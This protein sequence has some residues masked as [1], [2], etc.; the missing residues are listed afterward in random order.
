MNNLSN[1]NFKDDNKKELLSR[2]V[3]RYLRNEVINRMSNF[4][5]DLLLSESEIS[6]TFNVSRTPVR[7]AINRLYAEGLIVINPNRGILINKLSLDDLNELMQIRIAIEGLAIKFASKNIT[8]KKIDKLK[9]ILFKLKECA[10]S[11]NNKCFS[12]LDTSFHDLIVDF[13]KSKRLKSIYTN[14]QDQY[15]AF[16]IKSFNNLSRLEEAY[17]E[18]EKIISALESYD[19]LKAE[20]LLKE[21]INN[22]RRNILNNL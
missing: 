15:L 11:R 17:S 7:E 22:G 6:R 8:K 4:N 3:Y 13:S 19:E 1:N 5:D 9:D 18:I 20:K 2:K 16:R 10:D 14:L 12:D 21:H